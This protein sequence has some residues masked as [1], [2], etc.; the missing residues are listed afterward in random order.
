MNEMT[1]LPATFGLLGFLQGLLGL[2]LVLGPVFVVGFVVYHL[3]AKPMRQRESAQLFVDLLQTSLNCGKS[4]LHTITAASRTGDRDIDDRFHDVATELS[5]GASLTEAIERVPGWLPAPLAAL[6]KV[7]EK[8]GRLKELLPAADQIL[9][10]N[11]GQNRKARDYNIFMAVAVLPFALSILSILK[12]YIFPKFEAI[13]IDMEVGPLPPFMTWIS[14]ANPGWIS[15][16]S[17]VFC[18]TVITI[19]LCVG[20]PRKAYGDD[21]FGKSISFIQHRIPWRRRRMQ[22][23]FS[24]LFAIL[25]DAR[26][27]EAEAVS[28]AALASANGTF[29]DRANLVAAELSVGVSLPQ[30]IQRLDSSGEFQ[31]RLANATASGNR[32]Q[33]ALFAWQDE[34]D[35]VAFRQEQTAAHLTS[36]FLVLWHGFLVGGIAISAFQCLVNIVNSEG[37]LW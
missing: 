32:F 12:I 20:V 18:M 14:G 37:L 36:T 3:A 33:E 9:R 5:L 25:L 29:R 13:F 23:D 16:N 26:L 21:L 1:N 35:A 15:F 8:T 10:D 7:G 30:A 27:P 28:L 6:I 24:A 34:L 31:W 2:L 22:R 11:S 4:P 19:L 17:L